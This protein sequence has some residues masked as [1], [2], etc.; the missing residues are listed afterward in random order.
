MYGRYQAAALSITWIRSERVLFEYDS[1]KPEAW[2]SEFGD[3]VDSRHT[4]TMVRILEIL[5]LP[6][7]S[8]CWKHPP[9]LLLLLEMPLDFNSGP[10]F[11]Y[12]RQQTVSPDSTFKWFV[13]TRHPMSYQA[14]AAQNARYNPAFSMWLHFRVKLC[15]PPRPP[16][17]FTV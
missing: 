8:F 12:L 15:L 7:W 3:H 11:N 5:S 10:E 6:Y 17:E 1:D 4:R 9:G 2:K 13:M 14:W 16:F